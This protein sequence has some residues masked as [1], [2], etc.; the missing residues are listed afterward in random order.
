M[1]AGMQQILNDLSQQELGIMINDVAEDIGSGK[2]DRSVELSTVEN[3]VTDPDGK[4]IVS[5]TDKAWVQYS[6]QNLKAQYAALD[7]L[8]QAGRGEQHSLIFESAKDL[9]KWQAQTEAILKNAARMAKGI[10]HL[11][12]LLHVQEQ[13]LLLMILRLRIQQLLTASSL[14][15][16]NKLLREPKCIMKKLYHRKLV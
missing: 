16:P 13:R 3:V 4:E 10:V 8:K 15:K 1:T 5:F 2:L 14:M 11:T 7:I 12:L 6:D 9:E